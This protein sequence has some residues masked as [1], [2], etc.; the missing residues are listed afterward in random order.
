MVT[1]ADHGGAVDLTDS[2]VFN[3]QV[4]NLCGVAVLTLN[5]PPLDHV[6]TINQDP[7]HTIQFDE[8]QV[9]S[10][11]TTIQCPPIVFSVYNTLDGTAI[12]P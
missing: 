9:I 2:K 12:D 8:S 5:P 1:A 4:T 10:S 6:Y 11:E 7:P 3:L